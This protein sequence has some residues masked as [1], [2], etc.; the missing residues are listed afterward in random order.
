MSRQKTFNCRSRSNVN[1][2]AW[3]DLGKHEKESNSL[4]TRILANDNID[5]DAEGVLLMMCISDI[6]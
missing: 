1:I 2:A 4:T 6:Y 5:D 3:I